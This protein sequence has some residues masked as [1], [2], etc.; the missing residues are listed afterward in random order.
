MGRVDIM[1]CSHALISFFLATACLT[2]QA[3]GQFKDFHG[4]VDQ[5]WQGPTFKLSQGYPTE[6]PPMGDSP[7]LAI[8]FRTNPRDYLYAVLSYFLEGNVEVDWRVQDNT[9][10]KWY[11]APWM[12][13]D[14]YGREYVRGMTRERGGNL[15]ELTGIGDSQN[16]KRAPTWAVGFYNPLGG[17]TIAQVWKDSTQ[18]NPRASQFP[19]GTVAAKLLFTQFTAQDASFLAGSLEWQAAIHKDPAC[20]R[21]A[22]LADGSEPDKCDRAFPQTLRLAQLDIAVKD[23]RAG[24]T[25]WVFGTF[26]YNGNLAPGQS[27]LVRYGSPWNRLVP[28]GLIWGN[29]PTIAP[30][31]FGTLQETRILPTGNYQHLGCGG[32]LNGPI[33]NPVSSCLSCHM[34]AQFPVHAPPK[35]FA[36]KACDR[37]QSNMEYFRNIAPSEVFDHSVPGAQALDFSLQIQA[38][39]LDFSAAHPA[40]AMKDF[41]RMDPTAIIQALEILRR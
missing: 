32:R 2:T 13:W 31:S 4:T 40:A 7:W 38:G 5:G 6:M 39:L 3:H 8:D 12:E 17:Y 24:K 25:Q 18:P 10:R 9:K 11:H 28:V 16:P 15:V 22:P 20:R 26:V 33:D 36:P 37:E 29:D 34:S 14:T 35:P 19:E 23:S 30:Q 21:S 41:P 1:R 27:P